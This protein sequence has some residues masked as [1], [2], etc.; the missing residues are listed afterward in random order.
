MDIRKAQPLRDILKDKSLLKEKCY[1]DG[2]WVAG[3]TA[4]DVTNP[5]D[6]SVIGSVPKLGAA[7]TRTAIE[8]AQRAQKDWAKK[9]AKERSA[10]LRKWFTLMMEHQEDLAQIM[11]AEQGKPLA[12]SRGEVAYGASFIEFFAEEAK[13]IYG[14][15]IPSPWPAARM[16]VIK[17]PVGV[18]A[19]ITPWNFP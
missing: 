8:A 17:Q 9:T 7:E 10:I 1:I 19:A 2:Q 16:L 13:R 11:T 15:T 12:E 6:E 18:V 5:V 14:E 4:I 3:K